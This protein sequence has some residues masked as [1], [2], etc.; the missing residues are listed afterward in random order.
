MLKVEEIKA[1][2]D[3]D[4]TSPKKLRASTG[5][6]YYTG[7]HDILDYRMFYYNSD[8]ILT[9]DTTRSNRRIS[10]PFFTELVDQLAA[11]M[12]SFEEN[13]IRAKETADGLQEHL[14]A[15]FDDDFW[16]EIGDLI[17]GA[18]AKGFEYLY[19]YKDSRNNQDRLVFQCADSLGVVEVRE[20]DTDDGCAYVI[21]WYI[22][23]IEKGKK[24]ITR[25]QVH[26]PD[27]IAFYV[28]SS[29]DGRIELDKSKPVN[30][31]PNIIYTDKKG[32]RYG[33]SLGFIPFWRLDNCK[34]QTSGLEPIKA[35]IDDYDLMK[36]G[37]SNNLI[38]FD[39][40]LYAVKG[41]DGHTPDELMTNLRTKK[42][43]GT[44]ENG[45]IEVHTVDIPIDAR[46]ANLEEDKENIYRFGMGFN[47]G[48]VGDG[49]I[50]NV[51]IRSRYTLL[52]LKA[53]KVEKQL[54]KMLRQIIQ[55]VLDEI[56]AGGEAD[57]TLDD[58]Y[59]DF[60]RNVP[61]NEQENVAN[62]KTRA[63]TKQMEVNT[64]LNAAANIGDEAALAALCDILE[65][66]LE[67]VQGQIEKAAQEAPEAAQ[68]LLDQVVT[69]DEQEAE[70]GPAVT[71]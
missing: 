14:D 58:V 30:P 9:E 70:T 66:D 63:E 67:E 21:Y 17:T 33:K 32:N 15:Y 13:P 34:R 29:T 45:G 4:R 59:F 41:F 25:I 60:V 55:V 35:I 16:S 31:L 38:D 61:T 28:M 12:L 26:S 46:K 51:V 20:K 22:D 54:K 44:G 53:N 49:N 50:T 39:H 8:G 48:Q 3:A 6:R 2:I 43:V 57:Y 27:D 42:I 19:A 69:V 52:D 24:E 11:Y 40:P 68:G 65:L 47:S 36:C 7:R 10:H 56:N 64:I 5:Q 23:R 1:L 62:D 18:N 37:L 71:A